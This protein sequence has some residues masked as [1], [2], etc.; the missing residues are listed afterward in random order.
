MQGENS[1]ISVSDITVQ[2]CIRVKCYDLYRR[3]FRGHSIHL[4]QKQILLT[5]ARNEHRKFEI[6]D[7]FRTVR[8]PMEKL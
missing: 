1:D 5:M 8:W 6:A 3:R 4:E 7:T 2:K